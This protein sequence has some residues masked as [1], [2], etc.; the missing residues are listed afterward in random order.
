MNRGA[1]YLARTKDST[2]HSSYHSHQK[3]PVTPSRCST[4]LHGAPVVGTNSPRWWRC[5]PIE[6]APISSTYLGIGCSQILAGFRTN[7]S[8][9]NTHFCIS[10]N[11]EELSP[12]PMTAALKRNISGK[13][14]GTCHKRLKGDVKVR[15]NK[16]LHFFFTSNAIG[17]ETVSNCPKPAPP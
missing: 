5:H 12:K 8:K 2:S 15:L 1:L 10:W 17:S 3:K 14:L 7:P 11:N 16:D 9:K 6:P 13:V 4:V